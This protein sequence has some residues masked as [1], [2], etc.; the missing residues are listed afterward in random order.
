MAQTQ[1]SMSALFT[2]L[3][4]NTTRA[5]S[6]TD[7]RDAVESLRQREGES[8][9]SSAA[10][11]VVASTGVYVKAA[12]TSTLVAGAYEFDDD[13]GTDNRLMYTGAET[14]HCDVGAV[15]SMTSVAS[16]QVICFKIAK[17]GVV[18]DSSEVQ[19]KVGTGSDVGALVCRASTDLDTGDYV[20]LWVTN[21]TTSGNVTVELCNLH[22]TG[23]TE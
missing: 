19:R 7:L 15:I 9:I 13:S 11:T 12:G 4:D 2:L 22:V 18:I 17:N 5:I 8:Y 16:N 3:A 1:R 14:V 23:F 21:N 10:A 6:A 20:E